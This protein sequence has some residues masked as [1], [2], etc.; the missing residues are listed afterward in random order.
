MQIQTILVPTDFSDNAQVAVEKGCELARQL[1]ARVYLLHVQ[2][3][4]TLRTAIKAGLFEEGATDEVLQDKV[5]RMVETQFS[6]LSSA[7]DHTG[8]KIESLSLRGDPKSLISEYAKEIKADIVVVGMRG[9]TAAS[10]IVSAVI[11]S[12][13]EHVMRK[14]PCPT[15]VVRL[16]QR[17]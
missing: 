9:V 12:V 17:V 6:E 16:D 13:T 10:Q 15:L 11:G 14:S 7:L 2:D 4:S 5:K 1:G 8:M 3:E